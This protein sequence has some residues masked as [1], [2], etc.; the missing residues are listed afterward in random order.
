MPKALAC[1][2]LSVVLSGSCAVWLSGEAIQD[3]KM[4]S[5][6]PSRTPGTSH[7]S[8]PLAFMIGSL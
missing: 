4:I 8:R 5:T 3:L 1:S 6:I 2:A 7:F